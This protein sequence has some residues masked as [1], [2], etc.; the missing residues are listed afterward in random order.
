MTNNQ[1][2]D[3]YERMY[4][5][6]RFEE[7]AEELYAQ[8]KVTGS[9]HP[10]IGQEAIACVA[11]MSRKKGDLFTSTHRG[12]GHC[13]AGG[14]DINA[15]M[16][17]L[18]GKAT[19]ISG[20]KGGSMHIFDPRNGNIGT[21][22]IVAGGLSIACGAAMTLK[23]IDNTDNVVFSFFGEGGSNEG[24]T[25]ESM[26][27]ASVWKLPVI[28]IC[29][30]NQYEVFTTATESCSVQD[31]SQRA[32][33]YNMPGESVDGNDVSALNAVISKAVALARSGGGP[34][35]IEAR[36]Y[37]WGGHWPGDIYAYGGYRTKDEVDTWKQACPIIRLAKKL[38]QS[39]A[40]TL[41]E[42]KDIRERVER[43]VEAAVQF[44][45]MSPDPDPDMLMQHVF[46]GGN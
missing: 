2:K 12:L 33:A 13:I 46:E 43:Q 9:L 41:E 45:E 10:Y 7:R 29:E 3:I 15:I 27:L 30:N 8:G 5:S 19:G 42:F 17:E 39:K 24:V 28:F 40:A 38:E 1:L 31:V 25:H 36:T 18:F 16:A 23:F 37:R 21:N 35:L 14:S 4:L 6:R 22:G 11:L 20:G 34:S 32:C 44:A 26:N